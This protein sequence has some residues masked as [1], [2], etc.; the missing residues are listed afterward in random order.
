MTD[1]V[2]VAPKHA[3]KCRICN[4]PKKGHVCAGVAPAVAQPAEPDEYDQHVY[5]QICMNKYSSDN[6]KAG[7][8][9]SQ[10]CHFCCTSCF[11]M[12]VK[13]VSD[14][15]ASYKCTWCRKN[16]RIA[17]DTSN[18]PG[19]VVEPLASR[20][21]QFMRSS[22]ALDERSLARAA[23]SFIEY[24]YRLYQLELNQRLNRLPQ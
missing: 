8:L 16:F 2:P 12:L 24:H 23:H 20:F 11:N 19:P 3:Y 17:Y 22:E 10:S 15:R 13:K 14:D 6:I 4:Q 9:G 21:D 7:P 5:C 18:I 1:P